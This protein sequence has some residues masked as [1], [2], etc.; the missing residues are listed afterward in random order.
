MPFELYHYAVKTREELHEK[1]MRGRADT[2][3]DRR[4]EEEQYFKDHNVNEVELTAAKD[5]YLAT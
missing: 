3:H 5:F 4:N 2:V 1:V